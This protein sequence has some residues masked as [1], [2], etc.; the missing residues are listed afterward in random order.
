[1]AKRL[2]RFARFR[3]DTQAVLDEKPLH[4]GQQGSKW[5]R[6][7]H[8]WVLVWRSFVRNRCPV[9]ASALAYATLL[10]L[11]PMLAVA[12]SITSSFLKKEGQAGIEKFVVK[13]VAS[14]TPPATLSP[15]TNGAAFGSETAGNEQPSE[16][17]NAI[18]GELAN[19]VTV[20]GS[21][22]TD[23]TNTPAA[24]EERRLAAAQKAVAGNINRFIQNTQSGALGVTGSVLLIFAAISMLSRIEAT[25]NDIWGVARGRSWFMRVVLYWGVLT[26]AP[27]LLVLALGLATG[28]H[29]ETTKQFV[30]T[31]PIVGSFFF[32]FGLQLLPIA[33]LC[34]TFAAFYML[35]PNTKVHWRAALAGGLTSA[36]LFHLN[37]L[38]SVL[39]VSRVVSNSKIYGS[40]GLVPVFM[41]G[42]YFSW[43]ILLFGAQVAYAFQNRTTY[44]E[45]KQVETVNQRGREFV[46]LRLMT[47]IGQRY[48]RGEQAP[49]T[50]E[51]AEALGVPSRLVQQVMQ[52]LCSARL[53]VEAVGGETGYL[54]ARP[55]EQISCH[56]ILLAL[57]S[58]QGQEMA[59]RDEPTRAEVSGEF[60]RIQDAERE[61][62]SSVSM[63]AL[64][65]RAQRQLNQQEVKVLPAQGPG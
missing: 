40:L 53:T 7:A 11:I 61:A 14:V 19:T 2:S 45:D 13:L 30:S 56:D 17:T 65:H 51:M 12:M 25:F 39:Y 10:A 1:M 48:L 28:P 26:L 23:S 29:L 42:L 5:Q 62:A 31:L 54:P 9:R 3:A 59:T 50:A 58:S 27:L 41:I 36:L 57:R 52:T 4:A 60:Q 8:F 20:A 22:P 55:M 16:G 24:S 33:L 15:T 6:F 38:I 37:N 49:S 63:L 21:P 35:M 34:L 18:S 43:L 46:A 44:L 64:V 32:S 47:F